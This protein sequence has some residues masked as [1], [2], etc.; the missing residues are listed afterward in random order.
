MAD[1]LSSPSGDP[2][3]AA[4]ARSDESRAAVVPLVAESLAVETETLRVGAVRVRVEVE[5]VNERVGADLV[6]EEYRPTVRP[7]GA[8]A[9]ER[10]DPYRDG[11][12]LVVPIY[13][14]RV[15]VERRLFLKEEVR[16]T[17]VRH[18]EHRQ[19]E[20]PLRREHAVLERQQPDGSW[21]AVPLCAH[22]APL[23]DDTSPSPSQTGLE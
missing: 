6:S 14:E 13:E 20:V 16:L 10:L 8:P 17:R 3:C 2:A 9:S 11:D 22:G 1:P 18:V 19:G 5:H 4:V 12:D 23:A 21:R 7:V 15:V